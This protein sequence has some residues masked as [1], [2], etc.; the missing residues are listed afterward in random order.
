M[1]RNKAWDMTLDRF[2]LMNP[3]MTR[4]EYLSSLG[5]TGRRRLA[6]ET[7]AVAADR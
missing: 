6:G 3:G 2:E 4:E 5:R 1:P 7:E